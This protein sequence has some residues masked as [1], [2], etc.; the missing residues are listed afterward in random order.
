[1]TRKTNYYRDRDTFKEGPAFSKKILKK[2]LEKKD[3]RNLPNAIKSKDLNKILRYYEDESD[4][5]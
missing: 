5:E 3:G 1:M 4:D 2:E